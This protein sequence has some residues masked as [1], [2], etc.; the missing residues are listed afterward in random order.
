LETERLIL[1]PTE[2]TDFDA[3]ADYMADEQS[4]RYIGGVQARSEAWR[5]FCQLAGAWYLQGYSMFSVI[6]KADGRWI[7]RV[8]PWKPE[9]W[10]GTE[11]GW[12]IVR[13]CC[14]EG[15]ATEAAIAAINWAFAS[16]GW[17]DVIHV[18]RPENEAS[19]AV[20][21]KLGSRNRG[22][23]QLP[24]PYQDSIVEIWGQTR[25]EWEARRAL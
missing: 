12:G 3:Y 23:G 19:V 5:G 18:I 25:K 11:V 9:G 14:N 21:R 6:S 22:P 17:D 2:L 1:R 7:G 15:Y 16:L 20:A 13:T 24:P 4:A 8:G 10:P